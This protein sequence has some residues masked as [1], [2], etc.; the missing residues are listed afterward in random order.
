V[1]YAGTAVDVFEPD[2]CPLC[3]LAKAERDTARIDELVKFGVVA[4]GL[5]ED[6]AHLRWDDRDG[7]SLR[8]AIDDA[9]EKRDSEN[10]V[11]RLKRLMG[12]I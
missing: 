5:E 8:H 2:G 6:S 4:A 9:V 10:E 3:K 7:F 11:K 12:K 1:K